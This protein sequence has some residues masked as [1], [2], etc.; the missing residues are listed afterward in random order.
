MT[1]YKKANGD[2]LLVCDVCGCGRGGAKVDTTDAKPLNLAE[3]IRSYGWPAG[4]KIDVTDTCPRCVAA[5][6]RLAKAGRA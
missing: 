5:G 3:A 4:T 2:M 1:T 6:R